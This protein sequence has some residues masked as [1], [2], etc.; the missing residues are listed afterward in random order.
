MGKLRLRALL[1]LLLFASAALLSACA[2]R[3]Q[4]FTLTSFAYFDTVTT[5][6]GYAESREDFEAVC[7]RIFA[8]LEFWHRL[9]DPY[10]DYDGLHNLKTINDLAG[11]A[12]VSVQEGLLELIGYAL[13]AGEESG[14]RLNVAMGAVLRLWHDAREAAENGEGVPPSLESLREASAHCDPADVVLDRAAGTVLL[15]DPEL[16]LDLGAVAKGW[17]TERTARL[18]ERE[19]ITGYLLDVGGNVRAV[20]AKPDGA[21]WSVAIQ[22][23]EGGGYSAVALLKDASL[24]TSGSYQRFFEAD[25]VRYHHIIDPDTLFP[26]DRML[27]VTV[28]TAD[29]GRADALSTALF[30]LDPE[31][32]LRMVESLEGVEA[33]WIL[34]DGGVRMS[35]GMEG[36]LR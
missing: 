1:L 26:E 7:G 14:G 25:G 6:T 33:Y 34:P 27:S 16:S 36:N 23:P 24:V 21:P 19:G 12:P 15:R 18:L 8:E 17:A 3:L 10:H 2:P 31:D 4:R 29:A 35:S 32:G 5:V 20:G 30:N 9:A 13:A 22:A 11:A 28:L